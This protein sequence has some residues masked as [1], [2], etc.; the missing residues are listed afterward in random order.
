MKTTLRDVSTPKCHLSS[1]GSAMPPTQH[2]PLRLHRGHCS[3]GNGDSSVPCLMLFCT[4]SATKKLLLLGLGL[5]W[6]QAKIP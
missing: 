1:W 4:G 6:L 3:Q 5:R 2:Q